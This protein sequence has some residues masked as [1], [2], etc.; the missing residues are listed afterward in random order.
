[1]RATSLEKAT[2]LSL[3]QQGLST[4]TMAQQLGCSVMT[5]RKACQLHDVS[6][7]REK[8]SKACAHC[9]GVKSGPA[10]LFCSVACHKAHMFAELFAKFLSGEPVESSPKTLRKLVLKRDGNVC[11]KCENTK[12]QDEDI[13]L[14]LEHIDG[15]SDNNSSSNLKMLCP[16]CHAL[17]PTYKIKNKGRGR[18]SRRERY[19]EGL[20]Y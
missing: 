20:S 6:L 1:M 18:H 7:S 13:P 14:E 16:N 2:L 15:N 12:W 11:A 3:R 9:A 19:G 17:T 10:G 8:S 4:R 5:L